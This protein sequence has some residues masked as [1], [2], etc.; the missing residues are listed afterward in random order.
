M[1]QLPSCHLLASKTGLTPAGSI[2]HKA[3]GGLVVSWS[4]IVRWTE[5]GGNSR[6]SPTS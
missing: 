2:E 3:E 6:A 4:Q 1:A 5:A